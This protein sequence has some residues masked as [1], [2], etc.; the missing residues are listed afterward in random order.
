[1]LQARLVTGTSKIQSNHR[2]KSA[3]SSD[4]ESC[5]PSPSERPLECSPEPALSAASQTASLPLF[6]PPADMPSQ[7]GNGQAGTSDAQGMT[8]CSDMS[9]SPSGPNTGCSL[10]TGTE[11]SEDSPESCQEQSNRCTEVEESPIRGLVLLEHPAES[12]AIAQRVG[13]VLQEGASVHISDHDSHVIRLPQQGLPQ[14]SNCLSLADKASRLQ[15]Q[16][17]DDIDD[18]VSS[19]GEAELANEAAGPAKEP[20]QQSPYQ[21]QEPPSTLPCGSDGDA[22]QMQPHSY[23]SSEGAQAP[24]HPHSGPE[25]AQACQRN[26]MVPEDLA[27]ISEV[28]A[29][30]Q[31]IPHVNDHA[32]SSVGEI[33][34]RDD[35]SQLSTDSPAAPDMGSAQAS[36]APTRQIATP[37]PQDMARTT[38]ALAGLLPM[39]RLG[40]LQKVLLGGGVVIVAWLAAL[41]RTR[42]ILQ[43]LRF[44]LRVLSLYQEI[45]QRLQ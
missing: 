25:K 45:M 40:V 19:S 32:E 6:S 18:S 26:S 1:M 2:P 21:E 44:I 29:P 14:I 42:S 8:L 34:S 10:G 38:K 15:S 24:A 39:V 36:Q 43:P 16:P 7:A 20:L 13:R 23:S 31:S 12:Q 5:Q 30:L 27:P 41:Q 35:L 3:C 28:S 11:A 9:T 22:A 17:L 4:T 37:A 33:L